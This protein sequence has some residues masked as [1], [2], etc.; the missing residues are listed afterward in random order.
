MTFP[1]Y[2]VSI[3]QQMRIQS[4]AIRR[5]FAPHRGSAGENRED[6]VHRFLT[7]HLPKRF[8]VDTG[9][10]ISR[11]GQFSNQ[12]DLILVDD[13]NNAP[14]HG[15]SPNR[16]WPIEA[17]YALIEV[18]TLL[19]PSEIA[20]AIQKCRRFKKLNR[21]FMETLGPPKAVP[22]SL[23]VLWAYEGASSKTI[24]ENLQQAIQGI[25]G[26]EQPDLII[27]LG[28]VVGMSGCYL[29]TA[30]IGRPGSTLR[31]TLEARFGQDLSH[32]M[33]EPLELWDFGENALLAWFTWFDSWLRRAGSRAYDP[34]LY[35]PTDAALGAKIE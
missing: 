35:C 19:T 10:L 31:T 34:V 4:A 14:L 28:Q 22:E 16:L 27:V 12:A 15:M 9:L 33:P 32:L 18:K 7:A 11:E 13:L 17:A 24:K 3:T 26:S 6:L 20:D 25:P 5:D 23:F 1:E 8:R 2:F 21:S 30:R 29:E